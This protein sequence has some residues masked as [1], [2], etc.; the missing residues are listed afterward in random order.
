MTNF[1]EGYLKFC[2]GRRVSGE[3]KPLL[4]NVYDLIHT[5][6]VDLRALR[7]AIVSLMSFLC[8]PANRTDAN[9][10]AVGMFF[11]MDDHWSVRWS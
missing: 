2:R 3:L 6:P 11:L 7:E 10:R 1:H 5:W 4:A 9:C 8:E